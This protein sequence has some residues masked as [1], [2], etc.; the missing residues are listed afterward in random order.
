MKTQHIHGHWNVEISVL[1]NT[2]KSELEDDVHAY[3]TLCK[4]NG[5]FVYMNHTGHRREFT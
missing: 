2:V 3:I 5:E 4:H 1:E